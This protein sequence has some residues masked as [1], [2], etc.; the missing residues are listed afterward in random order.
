MSSV[1]WQATTTEV[2]GLLRAQFGGGGAPPAAEFELE[3]L[4]QR[5]AHYWK[6]ASEAE[7]DEAKT[8]AETEIKILKSTAR[9]LRAQAG[10]SATT[11]W[12]EM[13]ARVGS[14]VVK[15]VV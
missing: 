12:I 15:T 7:T 11:A 6:V 14:I 5:I 8:A 2:V 13:L 10:F 3:Q 4:A 1:D 9:M